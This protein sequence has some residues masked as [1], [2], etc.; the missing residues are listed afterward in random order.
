[1]RP[2]RRKIF[3][4]SLGVLS[5]I[6]LLLW[7]ILGLAW[8]GSYLRPTNPSHG[9]RLGQARVAL[10]HGQLLVAPAAEDSNRNGVDAELSG[11]QFLFSETVRREVGGRTSIQPE[12]TSK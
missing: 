1:M 10:R 8:L 6:S 3:Q 12:P 11:A 5:A 7:P 4:G 9:V 2:M